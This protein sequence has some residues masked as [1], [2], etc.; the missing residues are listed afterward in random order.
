[1]VSTTNKARDQS[2]WKYFHRLTTFIDMLYR[3]HVLD[4]DGGDT[5]IHDANRMIGAMQ[6]KAPY[7]T[8]T[9]G[10]LGNW[11]SYGGSQMTGPTAFYPPYLQHPISK[12]LFFATDR[13]YMRTVGDPSW[14]LVSG[15][16][17]DSETVYPL[18]ETKNVISSV[19]LSRSDTNRV[20]I[21]HY[22]GAIWR[23]SAGWPCN[24]LG[25]WVE[26][27]GPNVG[28]DGLPNAVVSS[29]AVHPTDPDRVYVTYSGFNLPGHNTVYTNGNGGT[30]AWQQLS[31]GLPSNVPANV[32]K[33]DPDDP[34]QLWLGTDRGIFMK[35]GANSW[36]TWGPGG[37]LPNVPVYDLAIDNFRGR[38]YAGT[39]GRGA[40]VLT[41]DPAIYTFEG[42]MD[43]EIWEYVFCAW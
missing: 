32:I 15:I 19:G 22:N 25:C 7:I 10:A 40:F 24:N 8:S 11:N 20:Y 3:D 12:V 37:R 23:S 9:G 28:G 18:I 2:S 14:T 36:D 16:F 31:D 34:T 21:G 5:A 35:D 29:I 26:I 1:M 6:R 4:A 17:D 38:V 13:L 43:G 33:V 41:N 27:G 30:G 39:F 42:W